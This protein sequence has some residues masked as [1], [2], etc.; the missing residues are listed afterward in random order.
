VKSSRCICQQLKRIVNNNLRRM[1]LA[2]GMKSFIKL[3]DK[4]TY[5]DK[6]ENL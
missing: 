3:R 1:Q 6:Q 4:N 5:K 2:R